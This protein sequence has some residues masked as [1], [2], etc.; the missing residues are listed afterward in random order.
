MFEPLVADPD[1]P[2]RDQVEQAYLYRWEVLMDAYATGHTAHLP[3]VYTGE[4]L[5]TRTDEIE[6][7]VAEGVRVGGHVEHNY[8]ITLINDSEAV[9][10]DGY[11]NHLVKLDPESGERISEPSGR[12][13]LHEFR[14]QKVGNQ[15]LIEHVAGHP[16][17][18]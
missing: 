16:V 11:R 2:L 14:F 12:L 8:E 5:A 18:E 17:P 3:H 13:L 1:L 10:M 7:M 6:G 4:A 15:W 9:V